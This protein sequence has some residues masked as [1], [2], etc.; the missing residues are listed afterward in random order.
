MVTFS[1][2]P[3]GICDRI[4]PRA[5]F[6]PQGLWNHPGFL[7]GQINKL[8]RTCPELA[9][10]LRRFNDWQ[11]DLFEGRTHLLREVHL[12]ILLCRA[13]SAKLLKK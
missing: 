3:P 5:E 9:E 13:K 6:I 10:G 11:G 12:L 7:T 2:T 4:G 8:R 1:G